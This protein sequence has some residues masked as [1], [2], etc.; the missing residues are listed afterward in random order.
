[1]TIESKF[2]TKERVIFAGSPVDILTK[3]FDAITNEWTYEVE[4]R[5]NRFKAWIKENQLKKIH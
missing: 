5:L 2:K 4:S 1:M 3:R